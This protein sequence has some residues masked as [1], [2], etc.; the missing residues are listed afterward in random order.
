MKIKIFTDSYAKFTK[1]ND[2][3]VFHFTK[4]T[5]FEYFDTFRIPYLVP[6]P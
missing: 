5:H 1:E 6:G 3:D 4:L 2:G